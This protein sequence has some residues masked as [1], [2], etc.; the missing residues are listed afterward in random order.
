[1][2]VNLQV[3]LFLRKENRVL[4]NATMRTKES[5]KPVTNTV[6]HQSFRPTFSVVSPKII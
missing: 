5:N 3:E 4:L 1:M 6:K 2:K